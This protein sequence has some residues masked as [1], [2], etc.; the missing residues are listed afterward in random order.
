MT[1]LLF[2]LAILLILE[3]PAEARHGVQ[4]SST[5]PVATGS[6]ATATVSTTIGLNSDCTIAGNLIVTT[7]G[8]FIIENHTLQVS[9]NI[10]LQGTGSTGGRLSIVNGTLSIPQASQAQWQI[11]VNDNSILTVVHSNVITSNS[12]T[13]TSASLTVN[14]S[15]RANFYDAAINTDSSNHGSYPTNAGCGSWLLANVN[16]STNPYTTPS[17]PSGLNV[18]CTSPNSVICANAPTEIYPGGVAAVNIRNDSFATIY[19]TATTTSSSFDIPNES[20][21]TGN[22]NLS[23]GGPEHHLVNAFN[24]NA[25]IAVQSSPGTFITLN[26]HCYTPSF[27]GAGNQQA[28]IQ[29][30]YYVSNN[31][32]DSTISATNFPVNAN[33]LT[34][35][36]SD[37]GTT[38]RTLC[39]NNVNFGIFAWSIYPSNQNGHLVTISGTS[40][41]PIFVNELGAICSQSAA[42]GG[43][44]INVTANYVEFQYANLAAVVGNSCPGTTINVT[45]SDIHSSPIVALGG[46]VINIS[47]S[48]LYGVVAESIQSGS[49]IAISSSTEGFNGTNPALNCSTNPPPVDS[50]GKPLCNPQAV[51]SA[52]SKYITDG[53]GTIT[54]QPACI[55]VNYAGPVVSGTT[56]VGQTL[57]TTNGVWSGC[58]NATGGAA[59]CTYA[60]QWNDS[61]TPTSGATNS[62]YVLQ[63]VDS[64]DMYTASVIATTTSGQSNP[65]SSTASVSPAVG[66][67]T[68][69]GVVISGTAQVG[70]TLTASGGS[71]A[72]QWYHEG[73]AISGAT[74]STYLVPTSDISNIISVTQG[75]VQSAKTTPVISATAYY[76][77]PAP[78]G[79]DSNT[80][81][82]SGSPWAT[83][84]KVNSQNSSTFPAGTSVLL[85][86]GG[87]FRNDGNSFSVGAHLSPSV[88]GTSGHPIVFDSYG[89]GANAVL[90]GSYD[91]SSTGNWTSCG[92]HI[93]CSVHQFFP[94]ANQNVNISNGSPDIGYTGV[95]PIVGQ[96]IVF[97]TT[98]GLPA[99]LSL[100]TGYYVLSVNGGGGTFRVATTPTGTAITPSSSGSGTQSAGMNGFPYH[101]AN[102]VGNLIWGCSATG[103]TNVPAGLNNCT[104]GFMIGGGVG[105]VWY[106]P[107]NGTTNLGTTAGN[108]NFN[109]DNYKIQVYSTTNPASA[110]TPGLRAAIDTSVFFVDS[111]S[112]VTLQ[113]ITMQYSGESCVMTGAN[114]QNNLVIRD[115]VCQWTGGA[116]IGGKSDA[117]SRN[118]DCWDFQGSFQNIL[119]ERSWCY[120]IYDAGVGPNAGGAHQDNVTARNDVFVSGNN[121]FAAFVNIGSPP[122][123]NGLYIYNNTIFDN[124]GGWSVGPPQQ[125]PNGTPN[126]I[127]TYLGL[128]TAQVIS[129]ENNAMAGIGSAGIDGTPWSSCNQFTGTWLNYNLW[130][131]IFPANT[132]SQVIFTAGGAACGLGNPSIKSWANARSLEANGVFDMDPI[133]TSQAAFNFAPGSGSPL[134]NAGTNLSGT[135]PSGN[136]TPAGLVWDINHN[137]RPAT[138]AVTIGAFQ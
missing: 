126:L 132:T 40:G 74:S 102:D 110:F 135:V 29:F 78:T 117:N 22:Y 121:A 48:T 118:G 20:V 128:P 77:C 91:L 32:A 52:C 112:F 84:T 21:A 106:K 105:G 75:G 25:R 4:L 18:Y 92:T 137:K 125:R 122:T 115:T 123:T 88:S 129:I 134:F 8:V 36:A 33:N 71:G 76:V 87:V 97:Y 47:S 109:T 51:I 55:P 60:Y 107:G 98:G 79:N 85:C 12:C 53:I 26:G 1:R 81:T 108:W 83:L 24:S 15:G 27:C 120:Q 114:T 127:G 49:R 73:A 69:G 96:G 41:A 59:S 23:F 67:I 104:T 90:D 11:Q 38:T 93:W 39:W 138:G 14:D 3:T 5:C 101:Q 89:A 86:A 16:N 82:S 9:G 94:I 35:C 70:Q 31:T 136:L 17:G 28:P 50:N 99:G 111:Q 43:T 7:G 37:G 57:T 68:G 130:P 116:N 103:G 6:P 63:S 61:G 56:V 45:N 58:V 19:L 46:G 10:T 133:F 34:G 72:F 54:G 66:P 62:T 113:N 131:K 65:Q 42:S 13:H 30:S 95:P 2:F 119:V 64:G 44:A 100:N 124:G 80:G